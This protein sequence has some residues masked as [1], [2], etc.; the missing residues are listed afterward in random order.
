M[1]YDRNR[2]NWQ[3]RPRSYPFFGV[4]TTAW[5]PPHP[6]APAWLVPSDKTDPQSEAPIMSYGR[7]RQ[8]RQK[9]PRS[10][11]F[12]SVQTAARLFIHPV[13]LARLVLLDETE[14]QSEASIMSFGRNRQKRPRSYP[15]F[16]VHITARLPDAPARLAPSDEMEPQ[17]EAPIISHGRNRQKRP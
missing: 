15:F 8:N 6:D 17:S 12:F 2:Q 1:S 9:R 4:Q 14:P 10:Y 16:G 13:V 7:N 3:K 5:L 11:P